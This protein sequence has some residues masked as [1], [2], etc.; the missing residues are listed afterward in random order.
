M[1]YRGSA[2]QSWGSRGDS[3][4]QG[5][6]LTESPQRVIFQ[7]GG[8]GRRGRGGWREGQ[9][10]AAPRLGPQARLCGLENEALE[11]QGALEDAAPPDAPQRPAVLQRTTGVT[12]PG[13]VAACQPPMGR[14]AAVPHRAPVSLPPTLLAW[15]SRWAPGQERD[16]IRTVGGSF[17]TRREPA[18]DLP[19]A[20]APRSQAIQL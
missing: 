6:G 5:A 7:P 12:L 17:G 1:R 10:P 4:A 13:W 8:S 15:G 2:R 16:V 3:V 19:P 14:E 9:C 20:A 11:W 18:R